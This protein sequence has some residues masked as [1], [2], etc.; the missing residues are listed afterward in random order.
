M[1]FNEI[2]LTI[3]EWI[4]KNYL[5]LTI[6]FGVVIV[7]VLVVIIYISIEKSKENELK[8]KFDSVYFA[9]INSSSADDA[10]KQKKFEDFI[11]TLQEISSTGK[12]Y[13]IVAIAN[14]ILGDI[15]YNNEGRS[16]DVALNY[17]SRATNA[18][19]DFLKTV[20]IFN[21]AQTYEELGMFD[22]ALKNYEIVFTHYNNSFLAPISMFNASKI[23][24]TSGNLDKARELLYQIS[25]KYPDSYVNNLD[26][27][28]ELIIDYSK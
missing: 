21:V 9:Y 25:N 17:Y 4:K 14:I 20:A 23:Y 5:Y 11:S 10:T 3:W 13:N 26:N 8:S 16:Y 28:M 15:Y 19:S 18:P 24:Y 22:L 7:I 12:N 6:G 27:L 1:N 2:W